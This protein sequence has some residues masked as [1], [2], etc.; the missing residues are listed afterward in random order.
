MARIRTIKPDFFTSEDIVALSPLARLL[1]IATWVEADREGRFAWRPQTLKLRYLPG[2]SC[3]ITALAEEIVK[4]GLVV[5]YDIDGQTYAEIPSFTRHQVINNREAAS[6]IAPRPV[7]AFPTRASH[8]NDACPT[9]DDAT[10]TPLVG[11]ERK[12]KEG[13]TTRRVTRD[14]SALFDQF[15]NAYPRKVGK[16]DAEK[17]F[18]KIKSPEETLPLILSAIESQKQSEQ[19]RK[20]DGQFIPHPATWLNGGR[21]LDGEQSAS[22]RTPESEWS[23]ESRSAF[24]AWKASGLAPEDFIPLE[25]RQ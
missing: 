5:L 8:V 1:Y 21:W 16:K 23:S 3:N 2:D 20:D 22:G 25:D 18:S 11:K 9:R 12:G 14:V 7:D 17:S 10:A 19:W 24:F 13:D 15:W 4:A 6:S